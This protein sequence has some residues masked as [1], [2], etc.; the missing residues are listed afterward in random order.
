MKFVDGDKSVFNTLQPKFN[1][2]EEITLADKQ[3]YQILT[4]KVPLFSDNNELIGEIGL[5]SKLTDAAHHKLAF[6]MANDI[7][8]ESI[9]PKNRKYCLPDPYDGTQKVYLSLREKQCLE[10]W[11][12]GKVS[13][14]IAAI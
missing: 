8:Q 4:S 14:E 9:I 11:V 7:L 5:F 12:L 3:T 2:L 1:K 10:Q 6:F 13:K